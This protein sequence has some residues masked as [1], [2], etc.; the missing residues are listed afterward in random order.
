VPEEFAGE[1]A[2]LFADV[3]GGDDAGPGRVDRQADTFDEFL[4]SE[5]DAV[6]R[7]WST[8]VHTFE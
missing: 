5:E 8:E 6:R 1:V 4:A 3:A 7:V 2:A